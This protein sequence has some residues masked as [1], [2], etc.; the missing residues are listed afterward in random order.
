MNN[1]DPRRALVLLVNSSYPIIYLE[2]WEE[3][4]AT[5]ILAGVAEDLGV[6][7]YEWAA[8]TGLARAGGA[9]IFNSQ[10]PGQ[11]LAAI[12]SITGDGLFVFKDFHKYLE[13]DVIVRKLR[14]LAQEF[15][16][17]QAR[18]HH[19][20][21]VVTIPVELEKDTARVALGSAR[22]GGN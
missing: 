12:T 7:L 6:P 22:R 1:H 9:P 2:T 13:Q 19:T 3:A 8:T 14:D 11:A 21:P 15:R 5:A 4:R 18:H 10:D 17:A 16:R 20:S